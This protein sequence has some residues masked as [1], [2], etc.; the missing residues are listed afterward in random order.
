MA[1]ADLGIV[2][3]EH[4]LRLTPWPVAFDDAGDGDVADGELSHSAP[5]FIAFRFSLPP[6]FASI[7]DIAAW[8][9][10][11]RSSNE[12]G[13]PPRGAIGLKHEIYAAKRACR[14]KAM[15]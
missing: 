5:A 3:R 14:P 1:L 9:L 8:R 13:P 4:L 7:T 15:G 2:S 11:A 10:A 12:C 6:N